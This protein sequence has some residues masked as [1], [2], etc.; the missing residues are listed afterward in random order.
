MSLYHHVKDLVST[1]VGHWNRKETID[2]IDYV[3]KKL[4]NGSEIKTLLG[5]AKDNILSDN[6]SDAQDRFN[7]VNKMENL[8]KRLEDEKYISPIGKAFSYVTHNINY[9]HAFVSLATILTLGMYSGNVKAEYGTVNDANGRPVRVQTNGNQVYNA[10]TME[11]IGTVRED[12]RLSTNNGQFMNNNQ[13]QMD[14]YAKRKSMQQQ[15]QPTQQPQTQYIDEKITNVDD[16][17]KRAG[18]KMAAKDYKVAEKMYTNLL[19]A[20]KLKKDESLNVNANLAQIC[21]INNNLVASRIYFRSALSFA[22]KNSPIY[23][24]INNRLKELK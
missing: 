14:D 19:N 18:Q 7:D 17:L 22:K 24:Y 5:R 11:K 15:N 23:N 10:T 13:I 4:K 21:Y 3:C 12:G 2:K 8:E 9:K 1:S 20:S 16:Y 6:L